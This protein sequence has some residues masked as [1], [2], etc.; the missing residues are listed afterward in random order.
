MKILLQSLLLLLSF[1]LVFIWQQS[2][3]ANYTIQIIGFLIFIYVISTFAGTKKIKL[4]FLGG[5]LAVFILNT[6]ILLFIFSTGSISSSFF[7]LLYFA[8]FALVFVFDPTAIIV[9]CA[10]VI[11][12]FLPDALKDDVTGNFIRLGS[13]LLISPLAYLFGKEYQREGKEEEK[14]E[15]VK[16]KVEEYVDE[17]ED[18][19]QSVLEKEKGILKP[20]EVNQLNSIQQDAEKIREEVS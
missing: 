17:I 20:D 10:G 9:F 13:L 8:V 3:L 4:I 18:N 5:P 11:L 16:E 1:V 12:V 15:I 2:P 14:K 6:I 7:F 19:T